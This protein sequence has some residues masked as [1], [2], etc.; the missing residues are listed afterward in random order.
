MKNDY[1]IGSYWPS[2]S[3]EIALFI[4]LRDVVNWLLNKFLQHTIC[5]EFPKQ[6]KDMLKK[7][8]TLE[9]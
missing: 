3:H 5:R 4:A 9:H 6:E 1:S 7:W 2:C 8:G